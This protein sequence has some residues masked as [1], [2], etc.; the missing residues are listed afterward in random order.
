MASRVPFIRPV[1]TSEGTQ[2]SPWSG[3]GDGW[4]WGDE[5]NDWGCSVRMGVERRRGEV[6]D[7]CDTDPSDC[8]DL[9]RSPEGGTSRSQNVTKQGRRCKLTSRTVQRVRCLEPQDLVEGRGVQVPE[10]TVHDQRKRD[11]HGRRRCPG[12]DCVVRIPGEWNF[13][14]ESW[15]D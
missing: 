9:P 4:R 7:R 11:S 14:G 15:C 6:R 1:P 8:R 10:R 5:R 13:V 3:L 12:T 2:D